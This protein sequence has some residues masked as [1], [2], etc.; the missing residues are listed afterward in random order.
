ME[1]CRFPAPTNNNF[2]DKNDQPRAVHLPVVAI[3]ALRELKSSKVVGQRCIYFESNPVDRKSALAARWERIRSAANLSDFRWHDLRHSCA[4]LSAQKG[5][6]LVEIGS[7]LGHK[8]PSVTFRYAHLVQ[9]NPV[10]EHV[11][12]DDKVRGQ[13]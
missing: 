4:S 11:A 13:T 8:I 5:A 3:E 7:V 1:G 12:P 10:T 2:R 6:L 9:G